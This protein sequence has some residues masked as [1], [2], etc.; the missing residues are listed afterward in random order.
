MRP[1]LNGGTLGGRP[2]LQR[3]L[4]SKGFVTV[5]GAVDDAQRARLLALLEPEGLLRATRHPS[6][7][8]FAARHLLFTIPQLRAELTACGVTD[9]A[10][11]ILEA[12][13][14][15]VDATYFDKQAVA[16]WTVPVHQDRVLPV[17]LDRDRKHRVAPG[18]VTV[19][20]PSQA[21]LARLLALR[22]HFDLTD[23]DTGAL[24]V[25]PGSHATGVLGSE[26]ISQTPLSSF[27]P[28]VAQP[29]D[30]ILMRPLLLHRSSPS[31]G[32]GHRRVL[33]IVY[34][35]EQPDDGFRWRASAQQA[36]EADGRA[37]S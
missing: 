28:C 33:H 20:E 6:G 5:A 30:V 14:F 10:S 17:C 22:I 16:N 21:T 36:V 3:E 32:D 11:R 4:E 29:G 23:R 9:L 35:T 27:V 1:L 24:F 13:A 18:G 2:N 12:D 25:L 15:P 26:Q 37:S 8:V 7:I 34:A 19:A 31:T